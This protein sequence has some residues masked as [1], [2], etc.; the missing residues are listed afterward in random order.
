MW[1]LDDVRAIADPEMLRALNPLEDESL[2]PTP[3]MCG[4][5]PLATLP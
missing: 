3:Q 4:A 2:G 5:V 1:V